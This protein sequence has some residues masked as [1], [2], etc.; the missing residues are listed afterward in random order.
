MCKLVNIIAGD[1]HT[2]DVAQTLVKIDLTE[3]RKSMQLNKS[4]AII[5]VM[6]ACISLVRVVICMAPEKLWL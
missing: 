6:S 1:T 4:K 3:V 2:K 5:G